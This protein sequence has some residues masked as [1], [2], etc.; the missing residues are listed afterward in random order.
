MCKQSKQAPL[1][2]ASA[3]AVFRRAKI[4]RAGPPGAC[5]RYTIWNQDLSGISNLFRLPSLGVTGKPVTALVRLGYDSRRGRQT[6][7]GFEPRPALGKQRSR[8]YPI[9]IS[10]T[11]TLSD[12]NR[13]N[14]ELEAFEFRLR[15]LVTKLERTRTVRGTGTAAK[16]GGSF[17]LLSVQFRS[18][19]HGSSVVRSTTRDAGDP[20]SNP[21]LALP[22][23]P[24]CQWQGQL[25]SEPWPST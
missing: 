25:A 19:C 18:S 8:E 9:D 11:P 21:A 16:R 4:R 13:R 2:R 7:P 14:Q 20:G 22:G 5:A 6:R 17:L 12:A 10:A 23:N 24:A 3:T 1:T 15:R